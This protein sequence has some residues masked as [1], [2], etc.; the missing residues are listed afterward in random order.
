MGRAYLTGDVGLLSAIGRKT[1]KQSKA[2]EMDDLSD[3][4]SASYCL[5]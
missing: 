3:D 5:T 1:T 2:Q 4:L